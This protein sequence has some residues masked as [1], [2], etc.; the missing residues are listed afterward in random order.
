MQVGLFQIYH[1]NI[2][3]CIVLFTMHIVQATL[4]EVMQ[5]TNKKK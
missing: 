2:F 5:L 4:Q 1:Q 3:I